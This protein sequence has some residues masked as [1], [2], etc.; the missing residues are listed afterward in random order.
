MNRHTGTARLAPH[1]AL[2]HLARL[3]P[4]LAHA[5]FEL[6]DNALDAREEKIDVWVVLEEGTLTVIDTGTGMSPYLSERDKETVSRYQELMME[7]TLPAGYD[8][9]DE[10]SQ[11]AKGSLQFLAESIGLSGKTD[12]KLIGRHGIGFWG[13]LML[14]ASAEVITRT[15]E[16][17]FTF[18]PPTREQIERGN[19]TYTITPSGQHVTPWGKVLPHGTTV[20]LALN[21]DSQNALQPAAL[22][23]QLGMRYSGFIHEHTMD[24]TV[25]DRVTSAGKKQRGG[26]ELRVSPPKFLGALILDR[27]YKLKDGNKL[28]PYRVNLRYVEGKNTDGIRVRILGIDRCALHEVPGLEDLKSELSG[29]LT[30]HIELP[31]VIPLTTSKDRPQQGTVL[32]RWIKHLRAHVLREVLTQTQRHEAVL[33]D[34]RIASYAVVTT[35]AVTEALRALPHLL[36]PVFEQAVVQR[37]RPSKSANRIGAKTVRA[38][39]INEHSRGVSGVRVTVIGPE[40]ARTIETGT[41]GGILFGELPFGKYSISIEVPEGSKPVSRTEYTFWLDEQKSGYGGVFTIFTG[42]NPPVEKHSTLQQIVFRPLSDPL[43]LWDGSRLKLGIIVINSD[44]QLV[45]DA[46]D[47]CIKSGSWT[48]LDDIVAL[49]VASALAEYQHEGDTYQALTMATWLSAAIRAQLG[50]T[51]RR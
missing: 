6:T 48:K 15:K 8:V 38:T 26:L 1:R 10:L 31:T 17:T 2:L 36:T 32:S 22:V 5:L 14:A 12:Q 24:I 28:H 7:G 39:V 50:R 29:Q 19:L 35:Q 18:I 27:E 13:W 3:Y 46:R 40:Y 44:A 37:T 43:R 4:S 23:N 42:T 20:R 25:V 30:G 9:R 49:C 21:T 33:A 16:G 41:S 11:K 47:A 45:A 51:R 34:R